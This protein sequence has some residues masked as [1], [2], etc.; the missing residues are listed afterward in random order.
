MKDL[1]IIGGGPAAITAAIYAARAKMTITLVTEELGGY[2][3]KTDKIENYPGFK[4]ITGLELTK[5]L[6]EHLKSYD[7]E[8]IEDETVKTVKQE[9]NEVITELENG[10][11][12]KS[13]IAIIATGSKRKKLGIKGEQEFANKGITYCAVCDGSL[14]QDQEV[15]VIGGSYAGTKSAMYLSKI[16][17]KVYIIEIQNEL[18]GEELLIEQV[19][20][21]ENIEVITGAKTLEIYGDEYVKGLK[22]ETNNETKNLEVQGISIEIGLIPNSEITNVEKNKEG[23][24]I[25]TDDMKTSSNKIFAAGDVN[26]KGKEQIIIAAAQGCIAALKAK[27]ELK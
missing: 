26:N 16:A 18:S 7:V 1:T 11:I 2:L 17:K 10:Q 15:A 6:E 23:K 25:V 4:T 3:T 5:A 13:K 21:T 24:I 20:K 22:Y 9:N 27:E 19:K 12:L 8:I 14:F